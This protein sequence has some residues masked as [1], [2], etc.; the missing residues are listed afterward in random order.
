MKSD[1]TAEHVP[2][3]W[4]LSSVLSLLPLPPLEGFLVSFPLTFAPLGPACSPRASPTPA[5]T[6]A[7]HPGRDLS[8][9]ARRVEV[10]PGGILGGGCPP[11]P[12][13]CQQHPSFSGP[14]GQGQP[15]ITLDPN[16]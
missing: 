8:A 6:A 15:L 11:P 14:V 7:L 10:T 4:H 2:E 3:A 12:A 1:G 9:G 16:T 13:G 5:Q